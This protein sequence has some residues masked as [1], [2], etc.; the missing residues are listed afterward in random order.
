[1][2]D[3]AATITLNRP[4]VHNAL[5]IDMIREVS[6]LIDRYG[7]DPGIRMIIINAKGKNFSAGADLQWM[8]KG[9]E[10]TREELLGESR[11]LALLFNRI[12]NSSAVTLA[13]AA[14]KVLGGA[15]GIIAASDIAVA[16]ENTTFAFTEVKLGLVPATIA[17][18]VYRRVGNASKEWMITGRQVPAKEAMNRGLVDFIESKS[19]VDGKIESIKKQVLTG[20]PAA[21]EGIKKMFRDNLLTGHPDSLIDITAQ[22]IAE[23]RTSAEGQ[24]GIT[25]FFEKRKPGWSNEN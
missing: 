7:A 17:P 24:E 12:Y 14:G 5:N 8:K 6:G 4:E 23:Y 21:V 11:E 3:K 2:K 10:Q 20:G 19:S 18:Y 13:I 22:K 16:M 15:N 1:M 25:A 9:L